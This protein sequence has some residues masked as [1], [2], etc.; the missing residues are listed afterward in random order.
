MIT[1]QNADAA[2]KDYYID[3][4][5]AQLNESISPFFSAIAKSAENVSGKDV[6]VAVVRGY[7]GNVIAGEEDGSLPDPYKNRYVNI[8]MP[9][10]NLYGTIEISD[11]ALRASRD[12]SGAFVNLLNA[13]MEGLIS[14]ARQNF[15]RML[16]GD[17]TGKLCEISKRISYS[18]YEVT[19]VKDYFV[20]MQVDVC[21]ILGD[22]AS[23]GK[24]VFIEKI[25]KAASTVTF[26]REVT[27]SVVKGSIYV[28]GSK[29]N[30]LCGLG[31]IFN[32]ES[33]YGHSKS[34][35]A[36]FAPH[37]VDA[38]NALTE[39]IL[40]DTLDYMEE[41]FNSKISI[42]LCSYKTKKKIAA[43]VN[44]NR[45]VVNSID[46]RTGYGAVTVNDVPVY[47]DR[48][49]PDDRILFLNADD[50]SLYQLCDW[51]WLEDEDGK[52]LKQVPG[53]ASYSATLVKYAELICR[54]PC[55]QA[56]L[57]N[58]DPAAEDTD[59]TTT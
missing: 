58:F 30:E 50:F 3:A 12:S 38:G 23:D 52:I 17:G 41:Y 16:F 37:K 25:N 36:F 47:A 11:K 51:E 9:L 24:G 28:H 56:M 42:I 44:A 29:N 14:S 55:G 46:A 7:T 20:G 5:T 8:T 6:N 21:K 48:F 45:R 39:D 13:E 15:Q 57:Y 59:D 32:S 53:K 40:S 33:L 49:C 10:K 34:S 18:E 54:K 4:V 43:L 26:D 27:E 1:I 2:L 22:I 19:E 31:A 35:D